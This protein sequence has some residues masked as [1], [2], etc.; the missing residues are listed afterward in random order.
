[1]YFILIFVHLFF[2]LDYDNIHHWNI[3][4]GTSEVKRR[5]ELFECCILVNGVYFYMVIIIIVLQAVDQQ[6]FKN[7]QFNIEL[8]IHN[9][10]EYDYE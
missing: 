10:C 7:T 9:V 4:S 8:H 3:N 6:L 1:M 5:D 2:L